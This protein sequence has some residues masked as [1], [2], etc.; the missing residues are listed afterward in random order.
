MQLT[1]RDALI[2][3]DYQNDFITGT[4][5]VPGAIEILSKINHLIITALSGAAL[6]RSR[7]WHP[8]EHCSFIENGGI[9]PRHCVAWTWGA[10]YPEKLV[11]TDG[12]QR[13]LH[14]SKGQLIDREEYSAFQANH[15]SLH[16]WL[17]ALDIRN[18]VICG[19]ATEYC[20]KAT[21]LDARSFG[22]TTMVVKDGIAGL[23]EADKA[24]EEM[25]A[26]GVKLI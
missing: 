4:L 1:S 25:L 3:V 18:V 24:V 26:A 21:A 5:P 12:Y 16:Q 22:F 9:H 14:V 20:V 23:K 11:R 19:V 15:L 2:V 13:E 17:L 10:D 8:E 7:C 6:V